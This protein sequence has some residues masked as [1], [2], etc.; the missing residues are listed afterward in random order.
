M[1]PALAAWLVTQA[2]V[3]VRDRIGLRD[4]FGRLGL[5][6]MSAFEVRS[7]T[8]PGGGFPSRTSGGDVQKLPVFPAFELLARCPRMLNRLSRSVK[9]DRGSTPSVRTCPT[10]GTVRRRARGEDRR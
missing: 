7:K 10:W 5:L 9:D 1:T 8:G 6:S 4:K 2:M 3:T